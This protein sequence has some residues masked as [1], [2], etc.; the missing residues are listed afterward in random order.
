M[1]SVVTLGLAFCFSAL[2]PFAIL[3]LRK[4][5]Q[6]NR[7]GLISVLKDVFDLDNAPCSQEK[8]VPSFEFLKYKYSLQKME[9]S[10][11]GKSKGRDTPRWAFIVCS[12]PLVVMVFAFSVLA[13]SVLLAEI[14]KLDGDGWGIP[15]FLFLPPGVMDDKT[16]TVLWVVVVAFLGGYLFAIRGLLRAVNNFDLSPGSFI[17]AALQ[18]MLGVVTA[19]VIVVGGV[20]MSDTGVPGKGLAVAA[21]IVAAFL[22][23]FI[24]EFGLRALYRS[25]QLWLFKREDNTV[26]KSFQATPVE[27][28]DGIDTEIRSRLADFNIFTV[29]NLATANPIML[30][31]ETPYGIY[32]SLDWVAQA[33]LCAAVGPKVVLRLWT[34]GIR[35]IFDLERAVL[36]QC[37]STAQLRQA[38]GV[39]LLTD[40]DETIKR[41]FL[42]DAGTAKLSIDDA[43]VRAFV[44]NKLDDLHVHRLRQIMNRIAARLGDN[45]RRYT[46]WRVANSQ[47]TCRVSAISGENAATALSCCLMI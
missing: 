8:I 33:Q 22:I 18:L 30:F 29:Q 4:T 10:E 19:V 28:V 34:L 16:R 21:S 46:C 26:Y 39:A 44:E 20:N 38:V 6:V 23:G 13:L 36:V 5:I 31:V 32:Q 24:P 47:V 9:K 3:A 7:H 35:T 42:G 25:S 15:H 43:S 14:L 1:F 41:L 45:N 17:S 40:A 11:T 12:I 2:L 27:I 37:Y